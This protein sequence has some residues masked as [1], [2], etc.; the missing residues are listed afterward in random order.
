MVSDINFYNNNK[1]EH[2][3][4]NTFSMDQI[5]QSAA[6][7]SPIITSTL[8]NSQQQHHQLQQQLQQQQQQQQNNIITKPTT[9]SISPSCTVPS[10][11]INKP[12]NNFNINDDNTNKNNNN[13][14]NINN[15]INNNNND[16]IKLQ[17]EIYGFHRF[18]TSAKGDISISSLYKVLEEEIKQN[19][20]LKIK[21]LFINDST[22]NKLSPDSIVNKVLKQSQQIY[23]YVTCEK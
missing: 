2:I 21:I 19:Y 20:K 15:N 11:P 7:I 17:C 6:S 14:Y 8:T 9:T 13:N 18:I 3:K 5:C 4:A 23:L 1:D 12:L 10:S 22:H 16:N